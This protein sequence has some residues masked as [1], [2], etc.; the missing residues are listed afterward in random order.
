VSIPTSLLQVIGKSALPVI[1]GGV[2]SVVEIGSVIGSHVWEWWGKQKKEQERRAELESLAQ[3]TAAELRTIVRE[4]VAELAGS[5]SR[6][7]QSRLESYLLAVPAQVRRTLRRPSDVIG[8]TVPTDLALGRMEDLVPLLPPRPPRF[9]AG[10]RVDDFELI[11][12]LGIGGFGEVWKARN[13]FMPGAAPV[14]LKFCIDADAAASLRR[15]TTLLDRI[16]WEGTHPGIVQ[17]RHTFLS[18]EPPFLEYEL[19]DGGDLGGLIVEWHRQKGGPTPTEAARLIQRLA[20]IVAFAHARGITHRD[21]KPANIL[22]QGDASSSLRLK[23]AD[24]GIG[25]ITAET[26]TRAA[27]LTGLASTRTAASA[28]GGYSLYYAS[29]EQARGT[30]PADPRDDVHA[31]GVIW[32]QLLVG[33]L[34]AEAPRGPGW[35]KR[36]AAKGMSSEMIAFVEACTGSEREDRPATATEVAEQLGRLL[37]ETPTPTQRQL[38]R[39]TEPL[40]RVADSVAS[41]TRQFTEQKRRQKFVAGLATI[42]DALIG[43][44]RRRISRPWRILLLLLILST[45]CLVGGIAGSVSDA[46]GQANTR[47][48]NENLANISAL[49]HSSAEFTLKARISRGPQ[50]PAMIFEA[51]PVE[52][53]IENKS[54]PTLIAKMSR[55]KREAIEEYQKNARDSGDSIGTSLPTGIGVGV[56]VFILIVWGGLIIR[57]QRWMQQTR[58]VDE[59]LVWLQTEYPTEMAKFGDHDLRDPEVIDEIMKEFD[60]QLAAQPTS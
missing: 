19:V 1:T 5:Y 17:L 2:S 27:R 51:L 20:E 58:T 44:S 41:Q 35:K 33:D 26:A 34:T 12:L 50:D 49:N 59:T 43:M 38:T 30:A 31:I 55:A 8:R 7:D 45:S 21:L 36:L 14:A 42:R 18:A 9:A 53:G 28:C 39:D 56:L 48:F 54:S 16:Q 13:A 4:I 40:D 10:D 37:A 25:A 47:K 11:E 29:P 52:S 24:F 15:E 3:A 60:R 23:I 57:A 22:I 32:Y 46:M 6:A